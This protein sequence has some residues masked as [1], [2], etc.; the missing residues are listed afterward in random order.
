M[1][2]H[3]EKFSPEAQRVARWVIFPLLGVPPGLFLIIALTTPSDVFRIWPA[4]R[5]FIVVTQSVTSR[6]FP[7]VDLF[8]HASSTDFSQ[9]SAVATA[10]A[11]W[12]WLVLMATVFVI[13]VLAHKQV[14]RQFRHDHT[15]KQLLFYA[16]AA[17]F[18]AALCFF[19][20]FGL[21][22]DPGF[23]EGLTANSRLGYG[24]MGVFCVLFSGATI[25]MW[26][27]FVFALVDS[28]NEPRDA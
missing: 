14:R 7:W 3:A 6:A 18:F 20:F 27:V 9:V 23:A 1:R 19:G 4:L 25:G 24:V 11:F 2:Q 22:G 10:F 26:P 5:D 28:I 8:R 15:R 13:S 16:L 21:P 17:P 12:W